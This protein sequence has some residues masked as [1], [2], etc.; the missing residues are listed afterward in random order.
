MNSANKKTLLLFYKNHKNSVSGFDYIAWAQNMLEYD[1]ESDSLYKLSSLDKSENLFKIEDYFNR[2]IFELGIERP[3]F[4]KC[5]RVQISLHCIE[6]IENL[7]D[8]F[9]VVRD[10]F[11]IS[12]ELCHPIYLSIWIELDD[13]IDRIIYDDEH[14]KPDEIELRNRI[15]EESSICGNN[16]IKKGRTIR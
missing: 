5:A 10:I 8:P 7:R 14:Y 16:I 1:F 11:K 12:V 15:I 9:D 6:I 2:V 4:E 13:G 3:N